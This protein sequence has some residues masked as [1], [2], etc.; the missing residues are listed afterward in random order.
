M[1]PYSNDERCR[2]EAIRYLKGFRG[3]LF[4]EHPFWSIISAKLKDV[5]VTSGTYKG[6][7]VPTAATDGEFI[8]VNCPWFLSQQAKARKWIFLHEVGHNALGHQFRRGDRNPKRWNGACDQ[9][10]NLILKALGGFIPNWLCDDKY[11]GMSA[12]RIYSLLKRDQEA[13]EEQEKEEEGS[14]CGGEPGGEEQ[15]EGES[16]QSEDPSEDMEG[17]DEGSQSD[18]SKG[19]SADGDSDSTIP[20]GYDEPGQVWDATSPE[21]NPL[22][23]EEVSEKIEELANDI[24]VASM[25]SK[26]CGKGASPSLQRSM[27]RITKPKMNW[28]N[29]MDRWVKDKGKPSGRS[30][31]RLDRRAIQQGLYQPAEIKEG[32]DWLV[33]AVDI[34]YSISHPEFKAFM[35]HLDKIRSEVKVQKLT[36]L[37]FN[38]TIQHQQ[39]VHL[40]PADKTPKRLRTGGG[41]SFS[42]IFNW[43][44]RQPRQPEGVIVFT[45][46]CCEDYG[47]PTTAS[48]L[49]ASTDEIYTGLD[50]WY[51]NVPPFG[52]V[53]QVDISS[54]N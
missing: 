23:K 44:K 39:I 43:L 38:E 37:P 45:D 31:S 47:K 10:L 29:R 36:I 50:G 14:G 40:K 30:W 21:G 34:S 6:M 12:E 41:T 22:T 18:E 1:P 46:L 25:I 20:Q 52:D 8:I 33:V 54:D 26:K 32:M 9:E 48:V 17:N 3:E 2:R 24:Q 4:S 11:K 19:D 49:W 53:V 35:N 16:D 42:P 28:R 7:P 5:I 13:Q 15:S 27:D 51:S